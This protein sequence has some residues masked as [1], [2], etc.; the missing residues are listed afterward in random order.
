MLLFLFFLHFIKY[1]QRNVNMAH[2]DYIYIFLFPMFLLIFALC[3]FVSL[4][5]GV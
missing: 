3:N 2:Y 1:S 5:L 4:L